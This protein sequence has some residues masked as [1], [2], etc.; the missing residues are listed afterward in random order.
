MHYLLEKLQKDHRNLERILD[1]LTSQLDQFLAGRE[2]D[3]DLKIELLE[4][5][6]AYA[7]QGH[8]PLE[9]VM[10]SV[11]KPLVDEQADLLD[12]LMQQHQELAQL[13]RTFRYSLE[14]IYQ[15]GV[16][17]RDEL[18]VQGR[19]FIAL[20]RQH[21][22]LEEQEAFPLLDS[23]LREQDWASIIEQSPNHDDP[24]FDKPDKIR[25]Q[26]LFEYLSRVEQ[27]ETPA[28]G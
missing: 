15:G 12:R 10:F 11:A 25:F 19:E 24:V 4:Y 7:D 13:T 5:M 1:L 3:F 28:A 14:N 21:I 9:N 22:A 8:H 27:G 23:V 6:E 2:S 17:P 26:T 20:Q 18:E 16:M